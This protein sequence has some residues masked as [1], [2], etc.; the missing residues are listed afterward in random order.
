VVADNAANMKKAI[1]NAPKNICRFSYTLNLV[2]ENIKKDDA[3]V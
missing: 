3:I 2:P 1:M